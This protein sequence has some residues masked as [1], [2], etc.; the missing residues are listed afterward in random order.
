[1]TFFLL[2]FFVAALWVLPRLISRSAVKI[3]SRVPKKWVADYNAED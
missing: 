3:P 1:M 2:F